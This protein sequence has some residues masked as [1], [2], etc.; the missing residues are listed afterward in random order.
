MHPRLAPLAGARTP[1]LHFKLQGLGTRAKRH[2]TGNPSISESIAGKGRLG[3][4]PW[5]ASTTLGLQSVAKVL[6][7]SA[8]EDSEQSCEACCARARSLCGCTF[9]HP[10][11]GAINP[12]YAPSCRRMHASPASGSLQSNRDQVTCCT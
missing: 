6:R 9:K 12:A 7:S 3:P 10:A 1:T 8:G 5:S 2:L 4:G 11:Q